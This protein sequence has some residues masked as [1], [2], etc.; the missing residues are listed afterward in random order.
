MIVDIV[1]LDNRLEDYRGTFLYSSFSPVIISQPEHSAD[2]WFWVGR[3]LSDIDR[4]FVRLK[5]VE[6]F[7]GCVHEHLAV[8]FSP[9][10]AI[11]SMSDLRN[12]DTVNV[13]STRI[14]DDKSQIAHDYHPVSIGSILYE[15][16]HRTNL[17]TGTTI[18]ALSAELAYLSN[19]PEFQALRKVTNYHTPKSMMMNGRLIPADDEKELDLFFGVLNELIPVRY[20]KATRCS[21]IPI[22]SSY[23]HWEDREVMKSALTQFSTGVVNIPLEAIIRQSQ[24][25]DRRF[26]RIPRRQEFALTNDV[27]TGCADDISCKDSL[28]RLNKYI[29]ALPYVEI[30]FDCHFNGNNT[31]WVGGF[32]NAYTSNF[33][34]LHIDSMS[35]I[36]SKDL[37]L[38]IQQLKP[39]CELLAVLLE[40]SSR[41]F[42]VAAP[43]QS[44]SLY[45]SYNDDVYITYTYIDGTIKRY[46][47]DFVYLALGSR[48]M[49]DEYECS[50]FAPCL[51]H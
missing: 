51:T 30:R 1:Q 40:N 34:I 48:A 2:E 9:I 11:R 50:W 13:I 35:S 6:T 12:A 23:P 42:G 39:T 32:W 37:P 3:D 10:S 5:I 36:E 44:A 16:V 38:N 24:L 31:T 14:F 28:H 21:H 49:L 8:T 7:M 29:E 17:P 27:L 26:S 20:P 41:T 33:N 45:R 18:E 15:L 43:V 4:G 46:Y 25:R 22:Q 19:I 47:L